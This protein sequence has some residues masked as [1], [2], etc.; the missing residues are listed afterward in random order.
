MSKVI[1]FWRTFFLIRDIS[2][3]SKDRICQLSLRACWVHLVRIVVC[4]IIS[5]RSMEGIK[6]SVQ[7]IVQVYK[8]TCPPG[9]EE[10]EVGIFHH[11]KIDFP[12]CWEKIQG[13]GSTTQVEATVKDLCHT[14]T[15]SHLGLPNTWAAQSEPE[16][17][18]YFTV[19]Q[20]LLSTGNIYHTSQVQV[21][22]S[23]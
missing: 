2:A 7:S 22:N 21:V 1:Q 23:L 4:A 9:L 13:A 12:L 11:H 14:T 3:F 20:K 10:R 5:S 16:Q 6:N 18:L 19:I 15:G 17:Q 8:R